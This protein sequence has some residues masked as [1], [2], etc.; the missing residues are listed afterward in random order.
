MTESGID[1]T[2]FKKHHDS[3]GYEDLKGRKYDWLYKPKNMTR[4]QNKRIKAL[5]DSRLK[6]ARTWAIKER[7]MSLWHYESKTRARKGWEQWLS[8]ALR[9]RLDPIREAANTI[10]TQRWGI[11]NAI[12]LK[13]S[14]GPVE[15]FNRRIKMIKVVSRGCRN[16]ARFANAIYF[17]PGGLDLYPEGVLGKCY[18]LDQ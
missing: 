13:V 6:T 10:K 14:N 18:P 3:E 1:E 5:R 17:H 12:V 9:S 11:L 4:E 16:K 7:A 8:W 2:A 15:G